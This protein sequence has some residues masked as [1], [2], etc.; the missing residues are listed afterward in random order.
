MYLFINDIPV[1][2]VPSSDPVQLADYNHIVNATKESITPAKLIHRV[3]IL[4]AKEDHLNTLLDLLDTT[5]LTGLI[6]LTVLVE[7][8]AG[9]KNFLKTKFKVVKAAGGVV[10]N[11]NKVLMIFRLKKWDLPK[12]RINK[13]ESPREGAAREVEEECGVKV[14]IQSK[15]CT[16]WHTY[17]LKKNKILK[18]TVWYDMVATDYSQMKPQL[19]EEIEEVRWMS[20][21]EVYH[22][23]DNSYKSISFVFDVFYKNR[24]KA[25]AKT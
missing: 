13:D 9:F 18:K 21:K 2:L 24:K 3:I 12:G 1:T 14:E 11:K 7:D 23:L 8:Y 22:A 16:T 4:N 5:T 20:P 10:S 25:R 6:S 19:E 17:T 15:L